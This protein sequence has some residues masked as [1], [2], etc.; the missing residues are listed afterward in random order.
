MVHDEIS[1]QSLILFTCIHYKTM[2][3]AK[4][5]AVYETNT[6][7]CLTF[8]KKLCTS[9]EILIEF[10]TCAISFGHHVTESLK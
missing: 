4:S 6:Y 7:I 8:H 1:G 10:L 9:T 2:K 5:S 3:A